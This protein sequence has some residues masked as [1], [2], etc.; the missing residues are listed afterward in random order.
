MNSNSC[1]I[2][3]KKGGSTFPC[4]LCPCPTFLVS[5]VSDND[6]PILCNLCQT[7]ATSN[8]IIETI[9]TANI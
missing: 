6:D 2:S 4:K 3:I 8:V 9:L 1:N 7:W 5:N